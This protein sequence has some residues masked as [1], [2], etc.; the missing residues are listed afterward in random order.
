MAAGRAVVASDIPGYRSVIT[1]GKTGLLAHPGD[2][3][4]LAWAIC[5]LLGDEEERARLGHA[6]RLRAED[7]SWAQVGREV[8]DYYLELLAEREALTARRRA[9]LGPGY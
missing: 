7:F 1:N 3:E 8:E 2:S 9:L 4:Q 5:R 6:G